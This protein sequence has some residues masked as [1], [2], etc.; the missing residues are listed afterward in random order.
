M[1]TDNGRSKNKTTPVN[2]NPSTP[3]V[4]TL[5]DEYSGGRGNVDSVKLAAFIVTGVILLLP[6]LLPQSFLPSKVCLFLWVTDYPCP[7][8]GFTRSIWA[9]TRGDWYFALTN[10]PLSVI[11]YIGA[12]L[13]F[14]WSTAGLLFNIN[15]KGGRLFPFT[16]GRVRWMLIVG[17]S[18]ILINWI[19]RLLA[20][21]K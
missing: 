18:A 5:S 15:I 2:P 11:L 10:C 14:I 21:L 7:F 4:L 12:W 1:K 20:G 6:A 9:L 13:G 19:Y 17:F 16:A 8:C 3:Q